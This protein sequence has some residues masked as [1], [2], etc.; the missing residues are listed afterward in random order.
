MSV[1][2]FS[3]T[4][5]IT[6]IGVAWLIW[7]AMHAGSLYLLGFN[8]KVS[9]IDAVICNTLLLLASSVVSNTLRFY[10]PGKGQYLNIVAWCALLAGMWL[11]LSRWLLLYILK[12]EEVY[13]DVLNS[14][15]LMRGSTGFLLICGSALISMLYYTQQEQKENERRKRDAEKLA[16][17]AELFNLRQQLQPHFLFNSLNSISALIGRRPEEARTMIY[18]LSDFLRGTLRKEENEVVT[19]E[20]EFQHLQLYLDIEKVRFGHRLNTEIIRDETCGKLVLPAMLLQPL[21]ENAI[22]FGLYDTTGEVTISIEARCA[23]QYL[24]ISIRNPYDVDTVRP[25][26]G[27]GFGITGIKRRLYLLF[28]RTDLLETSGE[29]DIFTTVVRIPQI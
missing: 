1:S 2:S 25:K 10:Q 7:T 4:R 28:A 26:S 24:E 29:N 13:A 16:R 11:F 18:Q 6:Y 21:V 23:N 8:I 14:S 15:L 5:V 3:S 9:V 17:E 20:E 12:G 27:T 19:L 22:K